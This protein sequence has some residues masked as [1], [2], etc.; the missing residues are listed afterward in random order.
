MV[1]ELDRE[2]T[3]ELKE[4]ISLTTHQSIQ[5]N[6]S[7]EIIELSKNHAKIQLLATECE[8]VD[9]SKFIYSGAIFHAA[10]FCAIA[11]INKIGFSL[12]SSSIDFTAQIN[13]ED[14]LILTANSVTNSSGKKHIELIGEVNTIQV[15]KGEFIAVKIDEKSLI[16]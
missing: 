11:A 14:T 7:Y 12:I 15:L 16:K 4:Q 6:H 10:N 9:D 1:E 2:T 5:K 13:T 3:R 8:K